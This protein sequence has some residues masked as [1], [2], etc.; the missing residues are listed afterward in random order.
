MHDVVRN[1]RNPAM[2]HNKEHVSKK[3]TVDILK[4]KKKKIQQQIVK[5]IALGY[6]ITFMI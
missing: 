3:K 5:K 1:G 6:P 4:W 2:L